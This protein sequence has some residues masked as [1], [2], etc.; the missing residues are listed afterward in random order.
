MLKRVRI[1]PVCGAPRTGWS[2][3]AGLTVPQPQFLSFPFPMPTTSF[4]LV[5]NGYLGQ[6]V[7]EAAERSVNLYLELAPPGTTPRSPR[8]LTKTPGRRLF[9][10]VPIDDPP[11]R[12]LC[13]GYNRLFAAGKTTLYEVFAD[14]TWKNLSA[15]PGSMHFAEDTLPIVMFLNGS[16]LFFCSGGLGYLHNGVVLS[17][18]V[19][20]GYAGFLDGYFIAQQPNSNRFQIS[21]LAPD[22][23]NLGVGTDGQGGASWDP[24]DFGTKL[25]APDRLMVT[26]GDHEELWL[27]GERTTEPWYNAGAPLFPFARIQ[28]ALIE[29]GTI[30]PYSVAQLDNSLFGLGGNSYGGGVAFR[31]NGY[32]P[33]RVSNHAV[34]NAW[35]GYETLTDAVA[36]SYQENGHPMYVISFPTAGKTWGYDVASDGWHERGLW[37]TQTGRYDCDAARFHA[38]TFGKHL[39]GDYRNGNIYEA[40]VSIFD[41]AANGAN[42]ILRW[43]RSSP[44]ISQQMGWTYHQRLQVEMMVGGNNPHPEGSFVPPIDAFRAAGG[45][46]EVML[47]FSDDGGFTWSNSVMM[48]AGALGQYRF[49]V[50]RRQ[51]GRS[52]DRCYELSGSDPVQIA[53]TGADIDVPPGTA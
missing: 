46:P 1:P 23:N 48:S 33:Q 10:P 51:L 13:A 28:S 6:S 16:Q 49:R 9:N 17:Q 15:T 34:E 52:R 32:L 47:R 7:F 19:T 20:G 50:Q 53:I 5:G 4:P 18:P 37:N 44:H 25:A 41:D 36:Y 38:Y 26:I 27:I 3:I 14:G 29:Q 22:I 24:L 35:Q 42:K 45:L 40:N 11:L 30:A 39:V 12:G 31:M 8:F 2:R 43:L 21:D